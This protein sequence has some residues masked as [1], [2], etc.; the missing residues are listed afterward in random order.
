MFYY[1]FY[2]LREFWFGFNV[3]RYITFRAAAAST[4]AFLLSI[5]IGPILIRKLRQSNIVE[6]IVNRSHNPL[7]EKQ[8]SKQGTPTMGGILIV[9]VIILSTFLWAR[10][11][12]PYI[13]LALFSTLYLGLLGALDDYLKVKKYKS[14]GLTKSIKLSGQLI[15]GIIIGLFIFLN[16]SIGKNLEIPFF[17]DLVVN[18]GCFYI[19]FAALVISASSNAVNFTDGLDGLAIG[20]VSMVALAYGVMSYISGNIKISDYLNISYIFGSGELTIFCAAI[21]GTGLGFLWYNAYPAQVFMGDTG[22]LALGGAIGVVSLFIKKELL[23]IVAGGLFV[24]EA[25]SVILQIAAFRLTGKRLF[26][27]TPFHHIWQL[28]G[29]A[30]AKITVRFW[31]IAAILALLSLST[32]KLR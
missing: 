8:K 4:T 15:L 18:L 12:N 13:L 2:P 3:F 24:L 22:S 9:L 1:L 21:V 16:P 32:L 25:M 27:I 19:L 23:L 31:I 7:F 6:N 20:A 26:S 5:I 28:K 29:M 17:K 30:D 11:D 10:L 14:A